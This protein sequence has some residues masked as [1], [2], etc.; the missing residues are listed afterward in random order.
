M[1]KSYQVLDF[2]VQFFRSDLLYFFLR[3]IYHF[4]QPT[5]LLFNL[6]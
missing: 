2:S 5:L 1:V 3:Y 4:W 6:T